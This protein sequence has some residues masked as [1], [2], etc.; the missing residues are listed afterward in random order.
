MRSCCQDCSCNLS[1]MSNHR[2]ALQRRKPVLEIGLAV[3]GVPLLVLVAVTQTWQDTPASSPAASVRDLVTTSPTPS[4]VA[5]TTPSTPTPPPATD[6]AESSPQLN[7]ANARRIRR[8][9]RAEAERN[10]PLVTNGPLGE[11][12]A[13]VGKP[14]EGTITV[15]VANIPN[16]RA[17]AHWSSSVHA[18]TSPNPDFVTLNEVY[19]H[20]DEGI[21]AVAPCYTV[22]RADG[23]ENTPGAAG[24]SMNNALLYRSDTWT[25]LAGGMVKV[26]D[27][28]QGFLRGKAFLW[29]RFAVWSILQR[30]DGSIV[31][32]ISTH[33]PTNPGRFPGQHGN[34]AL[35]RFELYGKGMDTIVAM[36]D[37]LSSYGPVLIGG[38]MNSH[39]NQGTWCA[40]TKLGAAG[41][42]YTKD[43]GVMYLFYRDGV[44]VAS[45]R[46]VR[47]FS[48]H[49]ALISTL[50]M[51]GA[52]P[53]S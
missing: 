40:T 53:S 18:L 32:L 37:Q 6:H 11:V 8:A 42:G 47:I 28:D 46:Q 45:S 25:Q 34:P 24:Q 4:E 41:F 44:S 7:R 9:L 49:P 15:S 12:S 2:R 17:D 29:D 33:M 35:S 43:Q 30:D 36:V 26:V 16:T 5:T 51:N 19:K 38:D 13:P 31:S 23:P 1:L 21:E 48:D 3:V 14:V 50:N 22:H 39:P 20:S 52:G 10:E 27:D